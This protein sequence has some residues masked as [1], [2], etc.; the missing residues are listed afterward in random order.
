MIKILFFI[1]TLS[2][3]G[4]EK[5]LRT[6]VN[7][8]DQSR[9]DITVMTLWPEPAETCLAPGIQYESLYSE[10][11]RINH[12]RY[13]VEAA[14]N[15]AYPLHITG[16]YDIEVAYLECGPTKVMAG[17]NNR[18]ALKLA[19]VHCD[20]KKKVENPA[21]FV[22]QC[23]PWYQKFDKVVC[24]S[25]NVRQSFEELFGEEPET[26]VVYNVVDDQEIFGKAEIEN[27]EKKKYT[28]VS[29]GRLCEQKGYD[30]LL[31]AHNRLVKEGYDYDLWILGEG[32]DRKILESYITDNK[33]NDSVRLMGF[34]ENPYPYFAA[35]DLLVCSSRYEGLSTFVSEGLILGK[36]VVTTD[37]T[38]MRELLGDSEYGLIT[39]NSEAGI[40]QGLKKMLDDP[41]L[42]KKYEVL[43]RE[44]GKAFR[45]DRL[46]KQTED[47]FEEALG[48]KRAQ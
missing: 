17:S 48:V 44:R 26:A 32:T 39:E 9:F 25:E 46:V 37:C 45:K 27:I 10:K 30:R 47:F 12:L 33:L 7:N 31:A 36:A 15:L 20:L 16:D 38:G 4:A 35:A 29:A 23:M 40:Y 5:V 18:K 6:L 19:W 34:C 14:L 3:G 2:G 28:V 11:N 41:E 1:E 13:R 43:A 21:G 8:M 42:L 24:V 22:R